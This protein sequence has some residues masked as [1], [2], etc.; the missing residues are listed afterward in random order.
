M[1]VHS[2]VSNELTLRYFAWPDEKERHELRFRLVYEGSL[3]AAGASETRR[4]EKHEI[5]RSFHA[6]L[7]E[8]WNRSSELRE[9]AK[10]SPPL[11]SGSTAPTWLDHYANLYSR[12]GYRFMPLVRTEYG[13]VCSLDILFLRRDN[14]GDL[15]KS[16]G[17]LDNRL[18]VLLDA[19]RIP[20]TCDEVD[21]APRDGEDPFFCLLEDDN[22][23]NQINIT[24]DR[25]LTPV[26]TGRL[27][28]VVLVI[29]VRT[30]WVDWGEDG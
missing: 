24:T 27:N 28:D 11:A 26:G 16:G 15:V 20:Q 29:G 2:Q 4:R 12:C 1:C 30:F 5:R 6:Q 14:P 19:L 10:A 9:R 7:A 8:L 18:K 13:N 17:D 21:G 23:I 25:L 22:L 3:P